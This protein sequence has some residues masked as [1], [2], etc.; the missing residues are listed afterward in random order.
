L[1]ITLSCQPLIATWHINDYMHA[2]YRLAHCEREK[3]IVAQKLCLRGWWRHL[4]H[5]V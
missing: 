5:S 1:A 3:E 4:D 2:E